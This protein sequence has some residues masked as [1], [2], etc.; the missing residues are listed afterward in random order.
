MAKYINKRASEA[1]ARRAQ[2]ERDRIRRARNAEQDRLV[3]ARKHRSK[4]LLYAMSCRYLMSF[5][6]FCDRTI[7]RPGGFVN[8]LIVGGALFLMAPD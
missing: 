3:Q 8:V 1:E 2:V 7:T 4:A 5:R 6:Q